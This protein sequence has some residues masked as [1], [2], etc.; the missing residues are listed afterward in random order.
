MKVSLVTTCLN[1]IG[2]LGR[3]RHD[4]EMQ[5]RHPDEVVIVDAESSDGTVGALRKWARQD[6]RVTVIVEKCSVARGRNIAIAAARHKHILS[7]DLGVRLDSKWV[8]EMMRPFEDERAAEVVVG[9]YAVD[10]A[11][12]ASAAAR[13]EFYIDGDGVP[14][15]FDGAGRAVLRNGVFPSNRSVAYL[16]RVWRELGGL[17]EDLTRAADD[18]VFGR[19]IMQGGYRV[20]YAPGA[21]VYWS[22]HRRL[23]EFWKEQRIYGRGDGEAGIK[24][25]AAFRLYRKRLVP[26]FIVPLLVGLRTMTKQVKLGRLWRALYDGDVLAC[27][28]MPILSFGNGYAFGRGY[29]VGYE[30]GSEH[31]RDCRARVAGR[32]PV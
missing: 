11:T 25:P 24:M 27:A 31:C 15:L 8:E 3:L 12:V 16:R 6:S 5:T 7:T 22:R 28:Y 19:Q 14:F 18:S 1:E 17:P 30:Y 10:R 26:R 32:Q 23:R 4:L 29:I 21:V 9:S 20:E 13:A 2:S